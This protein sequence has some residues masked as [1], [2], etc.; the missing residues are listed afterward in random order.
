MFIARKETSRDRE[1]LLKLWAIVS[2]GKD[3]VLGGGGEQA[4]VSNGEI[5]H[6]NGGGKGGDG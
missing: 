2:E 5:S 6:K 1:T 4:C 3:K